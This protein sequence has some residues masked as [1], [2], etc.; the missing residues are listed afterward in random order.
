MSRNIPFFEMFA[1]LQASP[2][3]RLRLVGALLTY[4]QISQKD[5]SIELR[6][7]VRD[8]LTP[9]E[10]QSLKSMIGAVYG[11]SHV[12]SA[13]VLAEPEHDVRP[14]GGQSGQAGMREK[15]ELPPGGAPPD[16]SPPAEKRKRRRGPGRISRRCWGIPSRAA[17]F[18]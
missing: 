15:P 11:F 6:L 14:G 18:P 13:A 7:T 17:P 16:S 2:E 10:L 4:A 3:L 12:E 1:E 9:E 8:A 5:L